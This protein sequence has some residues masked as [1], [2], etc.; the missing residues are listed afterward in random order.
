MGQLDKQRQ[1]QYILWPRNPIG[2]LSQESVRHL[3]SRI[4]CIQQ[5]VNDL[6]VTFTWHLSEVHGSGEVNNLGSRRLR[7]HRVLL[8]IPIPSSR[9]QGLGDNSAKLIVASKD[10]YFCMY[11]ARYQRKENKQVLSIWHGIST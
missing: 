9:Q 5:N 4:M 1:D 8:G 11:S 2:S 7:D 6:E 3:L 10:E